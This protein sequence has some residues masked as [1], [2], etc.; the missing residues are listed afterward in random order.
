M[1]RLFI[2]R[3]ISL[4]EFNF[5]FKLTVRLVTVNEDADNHE[6]DNGDNFEYLHTILRFL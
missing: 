1:T 5:Y 3:L 2:N 4:P 6:G